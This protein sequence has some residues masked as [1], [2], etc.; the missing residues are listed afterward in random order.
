VM[1][2]ARSLHGGLDAVALSQVA[3]VK[4]LYLTP[5]QAVTLRLAI[6]PA[7]QA[8][9]ITS[10]VHADDAAAW[11][12]HCTGQLVLSQSRRSAPADLA[13][14]QAQCPSEIPR[15][16]C[17]RHFRA[18]GLEYGA[19]FQGIARLWQGDAQA[20][21]RLEAPAALQATLADFNAHPALL[22]VCFQTLAAALPMKREGSLVYMPIG[23]GEG[24]IHRPFT[25]HMW[26]HARITASDAS[27][28][29]GDI[30][31][32]DEA[33][34]RVLEIREC[35]AR[36]MGEEGGAATTT[37]LSAPQKLYQPEWV[38]QPRALPAP[39]AAARAGTWLVFGGTAELSDATMAALRAAACSPL[40][41][42]SGA[43]GVAVGNELQVDA[44]DENSW[45]RV[46]RHAGAANDLRGVIHLDAAGDA[47]AADSALGPDAERIDAA[48]ARTCLVTLAL[49]KALATTDAA[50]RARL[51]LVTRGTQAVAGHAVS[52]PLDAAVWGLGR[53]LGHGEHIDIWGGMM[54][55]PPSADA[56]DGALIADE[57][58]HGDAED[59][60]AW[61]DGQRH[62]MRLHECAPQVA[63]PVP[64][65]FRANASYLLTGGL[66]ALGLV[67]A[68]WLAERGARHLVLVGRE[69]LPPRDTWRSPGLPAATRQRIDAVHA[70]EAAG[71]SVRIE[72]LDV[73]D[74]S[75]LQGLLLRH[76]AAGHPPLRG[77]IH[78]AGVALPQLLAQMSA[79]DFS[80]VMP[81]KLH[82]AWNLHRAFEGR[83]LDFFTLFSSVASLVISMGQ[84]NY[85]AANAG[86]DALAHWRRAQGLPA[87][88][89]NWGPWGDVGM[90][91]QLDLLT[92]FHS[93]GFF[94]MS[95]LQGCHALGQ[96][97]S[98]RTGQAI[99]LGA[100][101]K[102]VGDT[103]PLGIA[104]PMLEHVI[105]DEALGQQGET[106]AS[107]PGG[108]FSAEYR[109]C[110]T[111]DERHAL[112]SQHVR[113]LACHVLR[114]EES[115][116]AAGDT[117][118]SRGMDSMMAIELK[119][120]IEHSLKVRVAIVDL[121]KGASA[122]AIAS[123]LGP[124][125]AALT[126]GEDDALTDIADAMQDLSPEQIAALLAEQETAE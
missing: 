47:L 7:T 5:D 120:R 94:P 29:T 80:A 81:A 99:V 107:A 61:R 46:L 108:S 91:T 82:G 109:A 9:S 48:I 25:P 58:L 38:A 6:E 72:S 126:L 10:R 76:D 79:R 21:A 42:R 16:S 68:K 74:L 4:A 11:Q 41:V 26:I 60:I 45:V 78:A 103:S 13:A 56:A 113:R 71:A 106:H 73:A 111:A 110:D 116:L 57:V 77:V 83:A 87:V 104:A 88:S 65:V 20:L 19:A 52:H 18:L 112:L 70:I 3:F 98:G 62:V 39:A 89:I 63:L 51:W 114:I 100:H 17:Y 66:G 69:G 93:R 22:D 37:S 55:L 27:G 84:G 31:L 85:A 34:E 28:M 35:R 32:Y 118:T 115:S 12:T 30:E 95:A 67:V 122:D 64:P 54:D 102:T 36:A 101:W 96:L 8:F 44:G 15:A 105:R 92:Y 97:M 75:A 33:G 53:V 123:M 50:E 40:R 23:I 24:R 2:A 86:L 49:G 43:G 119:N 90:A 121:L 1:H 59:Q 117:L 124:E 14:L 125:L